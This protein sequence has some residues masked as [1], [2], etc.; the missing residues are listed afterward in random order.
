MTTIA[1]PATQKAQHAFD[2][3]LTFA[4]RGRIVVQLGTA[5]LAAALLAVV[6]TALY[7]VLLAPGPPGELAGLM[8]EAD[9]AQRS[10]ARAIAQ[11]ERQARPVLARA[12]DPVVASREASILMAY[13]DRLSHL[14][15]VI[16]EVR[17]FLEENPG[18]SGGHTLLLAAYR[19]KDEVLR[20]V[21]S[22]PRGDRS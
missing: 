8:R 10:Y 6:S 14:D 5:L 3:P 22:L 15:A 20:E 19:E 12:G 13:R 9:A 16:A 2:V 21:L 4:E 1:A 18:H 11:L 17:G 7:E